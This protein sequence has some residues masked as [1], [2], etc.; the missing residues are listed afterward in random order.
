MN[1]LQFIFILILFASCRGTTKPLTQKDKD[2]ITAD[3]RQ[4]LDDYYSDI[5]NDG[6]LAEFR[7]LDSS[8][9]FFWVPPG[10]MTSILYDSVAAVIRKN[11][12][13]FTYV[14]NYWNVLRI[15][16]LSDELTSYSGRTFSKMIDTARKVYE[17]KLVETGF[18]IKRNN[19]WKLLCG[20][21]AI[22][23]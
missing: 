4:T 10:Y 23:N 22:I 12:L 19:K 18:M 7:Y 8:A 3:V 6:L 14:E 21:T 11:A 1:L 16:P 2:K 5:K 9:D 13:Q 20:Q 17:Y 15:T